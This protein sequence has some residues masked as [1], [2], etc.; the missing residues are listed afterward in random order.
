MGM[1]P[2]EGL[3][4]ATRSGSVDPS[5]VDFIA[6]KEGIDAGSVVQVLNKQSG[7]AGLSGHSPD[8][9]D[10]LERS[11]RGDERAGL[12]VDVFAYQVTKHIGAYAA[13][14]GEIDA[15]VFGGGIGEN[16]APVREKICSSLGVLGVAIDDA[17]NAAAAGVEADIATRASAVRVLVVPVDEMTVIARSI[18]E[19][20]EPGSG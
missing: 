9:R 19:M 16:A 3:V 17:A 12:A 8:M 10:L 11:A 2:L 4:M 7:L 1:T 5:I 20:A 15:I 14:L 6:R 13:A 18:T